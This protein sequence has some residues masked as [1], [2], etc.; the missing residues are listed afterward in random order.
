V[1]HTTEG[2]LRDEL[3]EADRLHLNDNGYAVWVAEL[4]RQLP[5][6]DPQNHAATGPAR[7]A[8]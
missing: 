8:P 5:W 2:A 6:L 4:R 1:Q 7:H 3:F